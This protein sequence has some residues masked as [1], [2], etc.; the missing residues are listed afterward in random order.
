MIARYKSLC[1]LVKNFQ[2]GLVGTNEYDFIKKQ[3]LL[4][5][6]KEDLVF[7]ISPNKS[8]KT[9]T[10]FIEKNRRTKITGPEWNS[11]FYGITI[12]GLILVRTIAPELDDITS[13]MIYDILTD[14]FNQKDLGDWRIRGLKTR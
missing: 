5:M 13:D 8:W 11:L 10:Q 7:P 9:T 12:K 3:H 14:I 4:E 1:N 2:W 6:R